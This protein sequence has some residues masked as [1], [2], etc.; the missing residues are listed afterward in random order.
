MMH[1]DRTG[2]RGDRLTRCCQKGCVIAP[3]MM[4]TIED[5]VVLVTRGRYRPTA[6]GRKGREGFVF[7]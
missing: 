5:N 7:F 6:V 2:F 1:E 4:L 3:M